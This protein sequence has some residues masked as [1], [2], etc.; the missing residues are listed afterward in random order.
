MRYT[1]S[2]SYA[3][4]VVTRPEI[5]AGEYCP[6]GRSE[7]HKSCGRYSLVAASAAAINSIF[8]ASGDI[9]TCGLDCLA[10]PACLSWSTSDN[11]LSWQPNEDT[12]IKQGHCQFYT[13]RV[14][15][16]V[17]E[18]EHEQWLWSND[19]SFAALFDYDCFDQNGNVCGEGMQR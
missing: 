19:D 4:S 9:S 15:D 18:Y 6:Q 16:I 5:P 2:N 17:D 8:V 7:S 11:K 3:H 13:Q 14:A 12:P 10:N 1:V